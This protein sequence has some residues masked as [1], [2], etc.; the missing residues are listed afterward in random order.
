MSD[1]ELDGCIFV[2]L[3]AHCAA[4]LSRF[5]VTLYGSPWSIMRNLSFMKRIRLSTLGACV[6][7]G[8]WSLSAW[9]LQ[10]SSAI[11]FVFKADSESFIIHVIVWLRFPHSTSTWD[12]AAWMS[13]IDFPSI[14]V[15]KENSIGDKITTR[16]AVP[17]TNIRS[18]SAI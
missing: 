14:G 4:H 3:H 17:Y 7:D 2:I 8:F 12:S 9:C 11:S 6:P 1:D 15:V 16:Y 5:L 13:V 18:A 10:S